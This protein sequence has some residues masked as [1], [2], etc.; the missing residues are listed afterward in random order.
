MGKNV[1][2]ESSA[3]DKRIALIV[4]SLSSFLAPF[5]ISAVNIALPDIA[6]DFHASAVQV[7]WFA[8]AYLLTT[9][10]FLVPFGRIAD[11]HG[12]KKVFTY[13]MVVYTSSSLLAA[14]SNS[15]MMLIG[16]R[17]VE[18]VGA[19]M[20]MGTGV[21]ILTSIFPPQE[22]GR[23]LGINVAAVY[24]GLS[25]GPGIGGFFTD[26]VG[27]R[28]VFLLN[29]PLGMTALAMIVWGLK[30]EWAGARGE[31]F[32]F[33][34]SLIYIISLPA[35][36]YGL[37]NLPEQHAVG[38]AFVTAGVLGSI[39]F[40]WWESRVE[41]PIL[42]VNLFRHNTV[43]AFSNLAALIN[44]SATFAVSFLLS[45]YL[46][47]TK[48]YSPFVAGLLL[49]PQPAVMTMLSPFAGRLSDRIEP[50]VVASVGMAVTTVGLL[51]FI[52]LGE[53]TS[54]ALIIVNLVILGIGFALFSSPNTNAIMS[55]VEKRSLGVAAGT[56]GTMRTIGQSFSMGAVM[57]IFAVYIG[58]A[59][60]TQ[61]VFP[62]FLTSVR[63]AFIFFTCL[64]FLGIFA[65]LAR[66][67][68]RRPEQAASSREG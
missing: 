41:H 34:G 63:V 45:L 59:Q 16:A 5:M 49:V 23:V 30:G 52:F 67:N 11:I 60:I 62:Q 10:M 38:A 53:G 22:R 4:A 20:I 29:V 43:F 12:R 17:L 36:I 56:M 27:W 7:S 48:G 14:L 46:Q 50:I 68:V 13:G 33:R 64:C 1:T 19:A 51:F 31:R 37:P 21:A 42:D 57:L 65:S 8:T 9:S 32:D 28:S 40:I 25:L 18:G 15:A 3:A 61:K 66:G 44:Y 58:S 39:I 6:R 26:F 47:Y 35:L 54:M 2:I 24:L 55:S